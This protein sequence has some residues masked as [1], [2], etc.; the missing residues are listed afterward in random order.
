MTT[1][2]G[3][4]AR[5]G[6]AVGILGVARRRSTPALARARSEWQG[7]RRAELTPTCAGVAVTGPERAGTYH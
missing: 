6:L 1:G 7:V 5:L 4:N 3:A 2:N